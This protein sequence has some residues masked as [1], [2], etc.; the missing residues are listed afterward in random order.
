MKT[1]EDQISI[2][3][4]LRMSRIL[5]VAAHAPDLYWYPYGDAWLE[6]RDH[7][8][9]S[10]L[11]ILLLIHGSWSLL[12]DLEEADRCTNSF[13]QIRQDLNQITMKRRRTLLFLFFSL[14]SL[15][16]F[17]HLQIWVLDEG[18][19]EGGGIG[20]GSC[21]VRKKTLLMSH[22]LLLFTLSFVAQ[23]QLLFFQPLPHT[24]KDLLFLNHSHSNHKKRLNGRWDKGTRRKHISRPPFSNFFVA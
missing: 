20:R 12:P 16:R 23:N 4:D 21:D 1:N 13:A 22:A 6:H 14:F 18:E 24:I 3:L 15:L 7:W 19:K 17:D 5:I 9:A 2:P 8:C 11:Q 10:T